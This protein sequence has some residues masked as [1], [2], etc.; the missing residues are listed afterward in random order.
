MLVF[1]VGEITHP[2][3]W[4]RV[5]ELLTHG[6]KGLVKGERMRIR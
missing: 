2:Q 3:V 6:D 1:R 5:R 4:L